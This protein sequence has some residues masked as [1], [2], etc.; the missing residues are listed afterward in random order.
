MTTFQ[1]QLI[2]KLLLGM[3]IFYYQA[4]RGRAIEMRPDLYSSLR[5]GSRSQ[6]HPL[7]QTHSQKFSSAGIKTLIKLNALCQTAIFE[8]STKQDPKITSYL[9]SMITTIYLCHSTWLCYKK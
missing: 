5:L 9:E 1:H 8:H 4:G 2:N 3:F 7:L 6:I